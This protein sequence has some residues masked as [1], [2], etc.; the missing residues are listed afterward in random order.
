MRGLASVVAV[1]MVTYLASLWVVGAVLALVGAALVMA[2]VWGLAGLGFALDLACGA[3]GHV[4]ARRRLRRRR[5]A[6][7]FVDR[8]FE[9]LR[10]RTPS[11]RRM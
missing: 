2:L 10:T 7:R 9:G 1:V 5:L 3:A 11:R 6:V 4:A 8:D